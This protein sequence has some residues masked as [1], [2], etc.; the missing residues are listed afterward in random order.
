MFILI[1]NRSPS[2]YSLFINKNKTLHRFNVSNAFKSNE[3]ENFE[4]I[5][6][7]FSIAIYYSQYSN[8]NNNKNQLLSFEILKDTECNLYSIVDPFLF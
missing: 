5:K 4:L 3:T 7:Q 6:C 2:I 8:N 1:W